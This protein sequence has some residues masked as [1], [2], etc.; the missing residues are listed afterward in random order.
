MS[1]PEDSIDDSDHSQDPQDDASDTNSDASETN[2]DAGFLDVMA[3]EGSDEESSEESEDDEQSV[4]DEPDFEFPQFLKL[5]FELRRR[6]WELFCPELRLKPRVLDFDV[7][8][9]SKRLDPQGRQAWTVRD[10]RTLEDLTAATRKVLAVH[11]ESRQMVLSVMTDELALDAG[12]GDAIVRFNPDTDVVSVLGGFHVHEAGAN[13]V[14]HL[15]GFA[16]KVK[17]VAIISLRRH[18]ER[19]DQV[20]VNMLEAFTNLETV[21]VVIPSSVF[22]GSSL[23]NWCASELVN[24]FFV[25]TFEKSAYLGEDTQSLYCWPDL[26]NHKDFANVHIQRPEFG[27]FPDAL[28]EHLTRRDLRPW[29]L[30]VWEQE[31]Q[32][33]KYERL[34]QLG[35]DVGNESEGDDRWEDYDDGFLPASSEGSAGE[36]DEYE[37][38]GIDDG[39]VLETYD[40]EGVLSDAEDEVEEEVVARFSSPEDEVTARFSSPEAD[41]E[42]EAPARGRKRR[43]VVDSE[44]EEE[45]EPVAKRVRTVQSEHEDDG[46]DDA[47][48]PAAEEPVT[49]DAEDS[50]EDSEDDEDG[51]EEDEEESEEDEEEDEPKQLSLA[52][53]LLAHRKENP[54]SDEDESSE[55]DED[56]EAED[57]DEDDEDEDGLISAMAED[58]DDDED[59]VQQDDFYD[60]GD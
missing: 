24:H 21:Y 26:H 1:D 12:S 25:E 32:L 38:D 22:R 6:I 55:P 48:Q 46:D 27:N 13:D 33:L 50:D 7:A 56:E 8:P 40:S 57:E 2:E 14:F 17:H 39:D 53:R 31:S 36:M 47:E 43:V 59:E 44:D 41:P 60:L 20:V 18:H 29:P 28:C 23:I 54:V 45:D 10:G 19:L 51:E 5:P 16:E 37:S 9:T 35:P 58:E 52:E 15:P 30:I 34:K 49:K 11:K 4:P 3:A 42:A